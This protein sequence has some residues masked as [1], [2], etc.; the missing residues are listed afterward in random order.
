MSVKKI[1]S[2]MLVLFTAV[3][4]LSALTIDININGSYEDEREPDSKKRRDDEYT[5][6]IIKTNV[7]D[8]QV[9]INGTHVGDTPYATIDLSPKRYDVEIRKNGYDTIRCKIYP[10]RYYTYTYNFTMI[11]TEGFISVKTNPSNADVYI[12]GSRVS[13]FPVSVYPGNYTVKVRKFGYQEFVKTVDVENHKTTSVEASLI[14]APFTIS[15]FEVSKTVINP[16]YTSAIGKTTVSF[17]VTNNGSADVYVCDRY[18]NIVWEYEFSSFNTWEQSVTWDGSGA[19]GDR[20]PDGIYTIKLSGYG[21]EFSEKIKLDRSFSY[22]LS[23][24][25]PSGSGIGT[26]PFAFASQVSYGKLFF[27]FGPSLTADSKSV[28]MNVFPLEGGLVLD[29]AEHFE[30]AGGIGGN[31]GSNDKS[32]LIASGSLKGTGT[33]NITS[34]FA[35]NYAGFVSYLYNPLKQTGAALGISMGMETSLL[36]AGMSAEYIFS[37]NRDY[38]Y[39]AAL[40]LTPSKNFKVSAW[41]NVINNNALEGGVEFVSMPGTGAFCIDAKAWIETPLTTNK[42]NVEINGQIGLSYFF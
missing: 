2:V 32:T 10:R 14:T 15:K 28:K 23:V 41:S 18:G 4:S 33:I 25:T 26:M 22:P 39:G 38:K 42:E 12:G 7:S 19:N 9:Y 30:L 16:D 6:V 29:F 36:Y 1:F 21:Y 13:S 35:M 27:N 34:G 5:G 24:F 37:K 40:S 8:A 31:I 20:L 3:F 17:Y 11:K